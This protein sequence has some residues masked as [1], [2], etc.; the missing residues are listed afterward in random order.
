MAQEHPRFTKFGS[1]ETTM[2]ETGD[3]DNM[4]KEERMR[5]VL[6]ILVES[7]LALPPAAIFYNLKERGAT[8]ERTSLDNYVREL[9]EDG[10]IERVDDRK[11]YYRATQKGRDYYFTF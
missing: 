3:R 8:F 1:M 2:I 7:G 9:R 11:G 4:G 5:Q 10:M 6:G